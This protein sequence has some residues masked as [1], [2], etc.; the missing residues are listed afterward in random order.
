MKGTKLTKLAALILSIVMLLSSAAVLTYADDP[1]GDTGSDSRESLANIKELLNAI[2]YEEYL[3]KYRDV[4]RAT[5]T[6]N[7]PL[8]EYQTEDEGYVW[9]NAAEGK[10]GREGLY[11]PQ[12]GSVSWTVNIPKTG[13][14]AMLIDYYPDE[15]R[16][17]S[18]ERVLMING[19]VPFA[20]ARFLTLVK[21]WINEYKQATVEPAK[22]ETVDALLQAAK[23]AGYTDAALTEDGKAITVS[24]PEVKTAAMTAFEAAHIVRYLQL[25]IKNNELRPTSVESPEWMTY[26]VKDSS[27]YFVDNFEFVLEAGEN[28][29]TLE[30]KNEPCTIGAIKLYP[31]DVP[32]SYADYIAQFSGEQPGQDT[33][34]LEAE[35]TNA[36]SHTTIYPLEDRSCAINSP[37][38]VKRTV[39]N[40]VGGD[41]WQTA[42]QWLEFNFKVETSGMYDVVSRFKQ[43]VL[44][45]MSVC[46]AMYLYSDGLNEGDK[47]YYNGAPFAEARELVYHYSTAWQTSRLSN[48][49]PY[50]SNGDGKINDKDENESYQVYLKGGVTYTIRFEVTLGV[51]GEV[52]NEVQD[53]LTRINDDYL[54]IIKLTGVTPDSLRDYGFTEVMP[55]TMIDLVRQSRRLAKLK[56]DKKNPY[57]EG[58]AERLTRIAGEKSSNAATLEKVARLL[59]EMGTDDDDVAKNLSSLKT[60]IGTLGTFLSDAQTQPLQLDYV[61]IQPAGEKLPAATP[62]WWQSFTHEIKGFFQSFFRDYNSLGA[63]EET[64]EGAVEVWLASARDQTQ[65]IRNM[66]NN[67]YTPVASVEPNN[68]N[69]GKSIAVDLK[70]VAGGT[71]LPSIL[72][73]SGPDVYLGLGQGDVINYAIRSAL[74]NIEGFG[75]F[76]EVKSRYNDA[77]MLV[78]GMADADNIMHY[79]GLPDSQSFP[80]M[81]VRTDILADLDLEV[82]E[83]WDQLMATIPTLQANNMQ[84]GLTTD[85]SIF[86]YQRGGD[87][88]ADNGMRINLDSQV[89]LRSFEF[90]CNLFTQ[91]SFPYSYNA[92]NRFRTGEMPIILGDYCG[93]YNQLKVFATEIEG[94]WEFLPLPGEVIKNE[95]G[96]T[97]INNV[98]VSGVSAIVM[99]KGCEGTAR[100]RAWNFMKW[101][102]GEDCQTTFANEMVAIL[103]PSAKQATANRAALQNMPWTTEEFKQVK[104]QFE[105]LA[106]VPNYPGSYIIG[107]Y[108]NFAFLSAYN[109]HKDPSESMLQYIQT[110]N[111]EIER[112][113]EEFNLETL[114]DGD[115]EYKDLRTKRVAQIN[116]LLE[117]MKKA[118]GYDS[119]YDALLQQIDQ[120]LRADNLAVLMAALDEVK[121]AVSEIDPDGSKYLA[122]K[123]EVMGYDMRDESLTK[124]QKRKIRNCFAYEVYKN[125]KQFCTQLTCCGE[126]LQDVIDLT[127]K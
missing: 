81:F 43:D 20:E 96:T 109:D 51:M 119:K 72:A 108:T 21:N 68:G 58:L 26:Y 66:I 42:G 50:D 36:T 90:M 86:L 47:G 88:F 107:R 74:L 62:N 22:K 15:G 77:A 106:S 85:Y 9:L 7:I 24:I 28:T 114:S 45:G 59:Y 54:N 76:E 112:K 17:T 53:T 120:A 18:I 35:F 52:V 75:D 14:Y 46:R 83:T 121:A 3:E 113:R 80:M 65:V 34:R 13:K 84:I 10:D 27:G 11:T 39:L 60:Y 93:T 41:K 104:A 55:D 116:E 40:T 69:D 19:K 111:K 123:I 87:L 44:D 56:E 127:T 67:D 100:D 79:Y 89:G 49:E 92:S 70:L 37:T 2:P 110:I 102:C 61:Q 29:I 4:P 33:V 125:S 115:V 97:S 30:S 1:A 73:D 12:D 71:L 94:K 57:E 16:T 95:D 32:M 98:V 82:P 126:F 124:D 118:D 31:L 122:D 63:L 38:D 25:D 5:D 91:Y 105:N 8:Q 101:Y 64:P 117:T 48:G 103:G 78:L 23:D 99:I 6:V